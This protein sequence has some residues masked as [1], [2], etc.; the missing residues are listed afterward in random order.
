MA[1]API[2]AELRK[3]ILP[4]NHAMSDTHGDLHFCRFDSAGRL[5]TGGALVLHNNFAERLQRR[6]GARLSAM[7]PALSELGPKPF[8]YIWHGN[9]AITADAVPH[10][11]KLA[12]GV[13]AWLGCNGRGLALATAIGGVLADAVKGVAESKLPLPFAALKPISL[14]GLATRVA[15]FGLLGYRWRDGR[16]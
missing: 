10:V 11:H 2:P 3:R 12:D 5:I 9:L 4:F 7:F 6:I 1:T 16:D 13:Y 15:P 8:E 14:H